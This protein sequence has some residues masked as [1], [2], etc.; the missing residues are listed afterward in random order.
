[1]IRTALVLLAALAPLTLETAQAAPVDA[2]ASYVV[3]VG[4]INVALVDDSTS[5]CT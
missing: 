5:T 2:R 1:M 3:T 4:G